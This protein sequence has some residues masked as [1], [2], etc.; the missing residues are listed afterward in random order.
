VATEAGAHAVPAHDVW[1]AGAYG[2]SLAGTVAIPGLSAGAARPATGSPQ[3]QLGAVVTI[4]ADWSTATVIAGAGGPTT[5]KY[6]PR[7]G[8]L[9]H[10]D[11][12]GRALIESGAGRVL[13]EPPRGNDWAWARWVLGQVL[14]FTASLNGLE[15]LHAGAVVIDDSA[16]ALLGRSGAGKS[17][18]VAALVRCGAA[19]LADDVVAIERAGDTV[20]AHPGPALLVLDRRHRAQ[21]AQLPGSDAGADGEIARLLTPIDVTPL[22]FVC[23]LDDGDGP[24]VAPMPSP[25]IAALL[26]ATYERVRRDP[27]RLRRQFELLGELA[28]CARF[29]RVRVRSGPNPDDLAGR[30]L[31]ALAGS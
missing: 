18:L 4:E 25:D 11:G 21:A 16:V 19:F 6:A 7:S 24:P 5:I 20:V 1:H 23:V 29:V 3:V 17:T 2:L 15:L 31:D 10:A 27:D 14:P 12:V 13:L 22:R 9:M 8:H 26:G 30:L 28:E